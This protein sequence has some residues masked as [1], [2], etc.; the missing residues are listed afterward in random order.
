MTKPDTTKPHKTES[1]RGITGF[2]A[3]IPRLRLLR[4]AI[5]DAHRWMAPKAK[6]R[7]T[8]AFCSWDEDALTMA[9][10]AARAALG[11]R[12]QDI[13]TLAVASTTMPNV[14][15]QHSAIIA[16][17][18]DLPTEIR[19]TDLGYS[20]RAG[21]SAL[22]SELTANNGESLLLASE[23][24][25]A[26]PASPH[27]Q[28]YGAGAAAFTIGSG[29]TEKIVAQLLA[30]ESTTS[31][32]VDHFR[33]S[34][35]KFDYYW[36]ERWVRDEGYSKVVTA[37]AARALQ[38]SGL[39]IDAINYLVIGSPSA[40][41]APLLAKKLGFSGTVV[42]PLKESCGFTGVADPLLGLIGALE[43]AAPGERILLLG[44]GQGCDAL[45]F[46]A[47]PALASYRSVRGLS[48]TIKEGVETDSYLRM[49]SFQGLYEPDW[50]M[51]G[52]K[53]VR[54]ALTDLYRSVDQIW[55]FHAGQ[56]A[57]CGTLQFPQLAYCVSC[58]APAEQFTQVSLADKSG[59][60]L[61]LTADYLT[62]HPSPPLYAGFIQFG[63]EARLLM[64]I[65]DVGP[66][67]ISEGTAVKMVFRIKD[68]D[69]LRGWTRYFW[70]ATPDLTTS[71]AE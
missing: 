57:D 70:K 6:G 47:T 65:A 22:I 55:K 17:V 14:D 31:A 61:T 12:S 49:L 39:G 45:I 18:L 26:K 68:R 32:L 58:Q 54:T 66:E 38:K 60:V 42:D 40:A 20:Q 28:L 33:K 25:L 11:N 7:G 37:T 53:E 19:T 46:E 43:Q 34:D 15:L 10:E 67:G 2:G 62:Y 71:E 5:A 51:R 3:Y 52:E 23:A 56:C 1:N 24:P 44:F 16:T 8:K 9:V 35:S 30:A 64:E 13:D 48:A 29:A 41:S 59:Q 50:G 69:S 36:E 21:T 27:E 4:T 63:N